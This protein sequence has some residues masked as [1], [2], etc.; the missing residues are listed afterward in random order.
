MSELP[1]R[2]ITQI[3][4]ASGNPDVLFALC[5]DGT[6]WRMSVTLGYTWAKLP[7]LPVDG[8]PV[9]TSIPSNPI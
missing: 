9:G 2:A 7:A 4:V 1:P 3:A 8:A 6:V 5:D